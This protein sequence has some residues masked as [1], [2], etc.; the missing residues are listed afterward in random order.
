MIRKRKFAKT[1]G[2]LIMAS[3]IVA[4]IYGSSAKAIIVTTAVDITPVIQAESNWCWAACA[5]IGGKNAKPNAIRNQ[6]E[7]VHFLKGTTAD[8]YPNEPGSL[9]DSVVGSEFVSNYIMAFDY[10]DVFTYSEITEHLAKGYVIQ[11]A[12]GYYNWLGIRVGGHMVVINC[13]QFAD[14]AGEDPYRLTYFDPWDGTS[15]TCTYDEFCDGSYN[16]REYDA[17]VYPEV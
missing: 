10:G 4:M 12:A 7:V 1:V 17:T 3:I 13:T 11:A 14:V 15:H 16:G 6:Y 9:S 5:E 8:A 2:C